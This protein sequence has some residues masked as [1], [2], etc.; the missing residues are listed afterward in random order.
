MKGSQITGLDYEIIKEAFKTQ[1]REIAVALLPWSECL[2]RMDQ[3]RA[4]G[5]LNRKISRS[6]RTLPLLGSVE[7]SKNSLL[8]LC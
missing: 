4:D 3:R 7:N 1:D 5:I 8:L 6:R 2:E